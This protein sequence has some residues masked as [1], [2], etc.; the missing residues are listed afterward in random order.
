[1]GGMFTFLKVRDELSAE[2]LTGFYKYP[3]G[4]TVERADAGQLAADGIELPG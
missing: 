3:K 4:T 1:M 2:D